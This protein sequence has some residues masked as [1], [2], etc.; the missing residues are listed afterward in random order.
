MS[1]RPPRCAAPTSTP[2]RSTS[3]GAGTR[4]PRRHGSLSPRR[5]RSP[6]PRAEAA[7]SLRMVLLKQVRRARLR[8]LHPPG[9]PQGAASSTRTPTPRCSAFWQPLGRQ[10]RVEGPITPVN[11]DEVEHYARTRSRASQLSALASPQSEPIESREWLE[12]RVAGARAGASGR[13]SCRSRRA[14]A[15]S[16]SRPTATSSGSRESNR[17]HDRFEYRPRCR[18]AAG[19]CAG[20]R[21]ERRSAVRERLDLHAVV[22]SRTPSS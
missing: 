7:P 15:A 22:V 18:A 1:E 14:G 17:L 2:T 11:R 8:V 21:P 3:S 6:R 19:T 9:Q 13:R 4:M 5:S 12:R 10:V 20:S 16:G